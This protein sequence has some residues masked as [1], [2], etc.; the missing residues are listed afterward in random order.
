MPSRPLM[1]M[2]PAAV[3]RAWLAAPALALLLL[4]Q[5]AAQDTAAG[6]AANGPLGRQQAA[7]SSAEPVAEPA[8][9]AAMRRPFLVQPYT[10]LTETYTDN[11]NLSP[12]KQGDLITQPSVGIRAA[13]NTPRL[14]GYL[15]YSLTGLWY[16]RGTASNQV[17][18]NLAASG[19]AAI[20][21]N[22][23]NVDLNGS[24]SQQAISAFGVQSPDTSLHNPNQTSVASFGVSPYLHGRLGDRFDYEA[25]LRYI[26]TRSNGSPLSNNTQSSQSFSIG[27][28]NV[29]R[30]INGSV[31]LSRT[32][33]DFREGRRTEEDM[34]RGMLSWNVTQ[35]FQASVI[36]GSESNNYVS[37]EKEQ[38]GIYGLAARWVPSP[39]TRLLADVERRFFGN[40]HNIGFT[41]RS[42]RTVWSFT[43]VRDVSTNNSPI[44]GSLGTAFDLFF[45]QFA[46][47]EPDPV[48]RRQLV[49]NYLLANG[50]D[51]NAD[52]I[53]RFL[54]S[55]VTLQRVQNLSFA[56]LG[57]RDTVSFSASQTWQEQL[58]TLTGVGGALASAAEL[59]QR[60]LLTSVS[61]RLTPNSTAAL[62][63]H[64]QRTTGTT[65][66]DQSTLRSLTALYTTR[67]GRRADL[68]LGARRTVFGSPTTPYNESA[69]FGTFRYEF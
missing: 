68:S 56:W 5:A 29:A 61:H 69:I 40:S 33:V 57:L 46:S 35:E 37:D 13:A 26:D 67:V 23:F 2:L 22:F 48:L 31:Q 14:K 54:N 27:D 41:H 32:V 9:A 65:D 11:A 21:E 50:I 51:P 8:A 66:A 4:G 39:R 42:A 7:P 64:V 53:A 17:L 63:F 30:K 18:H 19:N 47:V 20:V 36:G 58:N 25:R 45:Q 49:T 60:G 52:A 1:R 38:H 12:Q 28:T 62:T 10:S 16:A 43:D 6:A 3:G 59:H 34:L 24:I 55:A 15:D 44:F